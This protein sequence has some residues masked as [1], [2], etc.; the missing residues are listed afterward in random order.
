MFLNLPAR[1]YLDV[2]NVVRGY[3]FYDTASRTGVVTRFFNIQVGELDDS[4]FE[5]PR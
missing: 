4:I 3:D 5:F 2:E 1:V